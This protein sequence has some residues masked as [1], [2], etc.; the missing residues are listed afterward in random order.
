MTVAANVR[1]AEKSRGKVASIRAPWLLLFGRAGLFLGIQA[2]F[3]LGFLL[4]GVSN[5]WDAGAAWWP[6]VVIITNAICLVTLLRLY[7]GEGTSFWEIY[8]I[9]KEN[10]KGDLLA[11]LGLLVLGGP[12]G[13]LPNVLLAGW[14]FG[15]S[16]TVL[17]LLIRPLPLW[18]VYISLVAFP[19][20]QGLAEIPTYFSY[21][22]PRLQGQGMP[23][24]LSV[25]F[26]SLMLGLQ[27][28]AIPFVLDVRFIAW[29][30]LMYIPFA[31]LVGILLNW[32]PRLLPYIAVVHVLMD[33]SFA[34]ML[35]GA[36]Y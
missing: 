28:F 11:L 16:Q 30:A 17:A 9:R 26:P 34:S 18:A 15:D 10:I 21:V 2:L 13:Y 24:W 20:T 3:A 7:R 33:L 36:A 8:R 27:H 32:R 12:L 29:R 31:F 19:L 5:A 23:R 6:F 25:A 14:L 22:M 35:L 1:S 4:S